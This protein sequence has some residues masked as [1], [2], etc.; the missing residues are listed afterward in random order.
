VNWA[1]IGT[2]LQLL[3]VVTTGVGFWRTWREFA[4][5]REG[6][7]DP[8]AVPLRAG[9]RRGSLKV[10]GLIRRVFRRPK[11]VVV[12]AGSITVGAAAFNARGRVQ[13]GELPPT[14]KAAIAELHRRTKDLMD[15]VSDNRED[16]TDGLAAVRKEIADLAS[17]VDAVAAGLEQR[18]RRVAVGG[19][20]IEAA[21]LVLVALGTV[22]QSVAP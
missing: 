21:G 3:G 7:F 19:I 22:L 20:R 8:I 14:T 16:T 5:P 11:A 4:A 15:R 1:T 17:Q 2:A 18:T 6:F 10:E 12:G 9:W 13:F